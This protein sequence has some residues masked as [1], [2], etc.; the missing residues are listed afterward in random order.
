MSCCCCC[1]FQL[2]YI[3][4]NPGG[5]AANLT[6]ASSVYAYIGT[7]PAWR[8]Y[9][10]LS[11][12]QGPCHLVEEVLSPQI[13][14]TIFRLGPQYMGSF[15]SPQMNGTYCKLEV[16]NEGLSSHAVRNITSTKLT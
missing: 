3:S 9:S 1:L 15:Q 4:Q 5:G 16:I 13:V 14:S 7:A 2:H 12:K 8:R 10:R 11:W 6:V